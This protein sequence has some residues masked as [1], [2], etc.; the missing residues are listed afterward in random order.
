MKSPFAPLL[1]LPWLVASHL[2][3]GKVAHCADL[4]LSQAAYGSYGSVHCWWHL[5][6][7][8]WWSCFA[9]LASILPA[10]DH[11]RKAS[12]TLLALVVYWNSYEKKK[13]CFGWCRFH[14]QVR[15]CARDDT[16]SLGKGTALLTWCHLQSN[17]SKLSRCFFAEIEV[18]R[19]K[20]WFMS[21]N[22]FSTFVFASPKQ[23]LHLSG[24][25]LHLWSCFWAS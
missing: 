1:L 22:F 9:N 11:L 10:S 4:S 24:C 16:G 25:H 15:D 12:C 18:G 19:A 17:A 23:K 13:L 5:A 3:H 6:G 7:W 8:G 2:F 21:V 20:P 14:K